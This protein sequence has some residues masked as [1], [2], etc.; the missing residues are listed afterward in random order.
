MYSRIKGTDS[1]PTIT[2]RTDTE[3]NFIRCESE[4]IKNYLVHKIIQVT[5]KTA[6]SHYRMKNEISASICSFKKYRF[7]AKD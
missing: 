6:S 1:K 4:I 7:S 5:K 3:G 2:V